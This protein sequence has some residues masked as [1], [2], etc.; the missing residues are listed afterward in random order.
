VAAAVFLILV[1]TGCGNGAG[2]RGTFK[3]SRDGRIYRTVKI[4]NQIWM[5]ENLKYQANRSWCYDYADS[6]CVKYGRLYNWGIA[7]EACPAGWRLPDTSDW[8]SLVTFVGDSADT[9][10]KSRNWGGTDNYGF[11]ALPGGSGFGYDDGR[12]SSLGSECMWWTA[13]SDTPNDWTRETFGQLSDYVYANAYTWGLE[14]GDKD[15]GKFLTNK[16]SGISVRCV[17]D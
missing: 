6:N 10:L 13:T 15:W 2:T 11:S 16:F 4:G 9:K 3:D 7:M 14:P 8:R 12:F 1:L 5:A 17:Q